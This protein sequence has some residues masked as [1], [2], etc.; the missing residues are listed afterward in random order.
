MKGN[1]SCAPLAAMSSSLTTLR[2]VAV[3]QIASTL[4]LGPLSYSSDRASFKAFPRI[5][6]PTVFPVDDRPLL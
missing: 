6:R 1:G 3:A 4:T 5:A 2:T